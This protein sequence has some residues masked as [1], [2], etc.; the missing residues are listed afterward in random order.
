MSNLV[1]SLVQRRR[2]GSGVKKAVLMYFADR[3]SDDGSG[4]VNFSDADGVKPDRLRSLFGEGLSLGSVDA[5]S[6]E[7]AVA[8]LV[9]KS[10]PQKI[11]GDKYNQAKMKKYVID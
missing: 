6:F 8:V 9:A 4:G 11:I 2:I 5:E 3:S 10:H 7:K 1:A